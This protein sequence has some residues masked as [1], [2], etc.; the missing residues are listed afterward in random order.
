MLEEIDVAIKETGLNLDK[1]RR[2]QFAKRYAEERRKLEEQLRRETEEK[3]R[4]LVKEI[5][6]R[7]KTEFSAPGADAAAPPNLV[8]PQ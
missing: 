1:E 5:V 3:R 7:L 6:G 4:P 2:T 8:A